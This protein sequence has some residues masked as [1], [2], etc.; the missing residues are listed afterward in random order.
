VSERPASAEP[1]ASLPLRWSRY[2]VRQ[3]AGLLLIL[4]GAVL[5]LPTTAYTLPL[6]LLGAAAHASGWLILPAPG[7]RRLLAAVVSVSAVL[8]MMLVPQLAGLMA[9]PLALWFLVRRRPSRVYPLALAPAVA[10]VLVAQAAG[11]FGARLPALAVA[12][13]AAVAAAWAAS[14]L[15]VRSARP[16]SG[17]PLADR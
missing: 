13:A 17:N 11:P 6:G 8:L 2:G 9:V 12:A 14:A 1:N 15:S 3:T 4:V 16:I 7:G 5:V 10:G